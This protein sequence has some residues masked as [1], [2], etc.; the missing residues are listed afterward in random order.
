MK[1]NLPN[2]FDRHDNTRTKSGCATCVALIAGLMGS[3][4][5]LAEDVQADPSP[6]IDAPA[7]YKVTDENTTLYLYG[8]FHLL[9]SAVQWHSDAYAEA[10][11]ASPRTIVEA[12]V[13]SP[14]AQA[15]IQ[16]LIPQLGLNQAGVTLSDTLGEERAARFET[17]L[18]HYGVP[19]AALEQMRP[20]LASLSL[21]QIAYSQAGFDPASGVETSVLAQAAE[22]GDTLGY[23]ETATFQLETLAG[24]DEAELLASFDLGLEDIIAMDEMIQN[25]VEAWR[26]GNV[27]RLDDVLVAEARTTAPGMFEAVFAGRNRNWVDQIEIF[28]AEDQDAFIAVGA[29]HLVGKDSVIDMLV[30]RGISVERIQ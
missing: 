3:T 12:D 5:A 10:M 30:E 24:L 16:A 9:P 28:L 19:L 21:A 18:A 6:A 26:T 15:Q 22:E 14:Q 23:L 7:M 8:T 17:A 25:G 1:F 29:G 2:A 13:Q 27:Q 20:W 11:A 4:A